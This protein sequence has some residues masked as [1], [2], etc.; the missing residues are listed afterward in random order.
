M[1]LPDKRC[2]I[3]V[4]QPS[5][6]LNDCRMGFNPAIDIFLVE[7]D[8][9]AFTTY[10][11][12]RVPPS[13]GF[14]YIYKTDIITGHCR[15][16]SGKPNQ[17]IYHTHLVDKGNGFNMGQIILGNVHFFTGEIAQP[18]SS[19]AYFSGQSGIFLHTILNTGHIYIF[20]HRLQPFASQD[21]LHF[22]TGRTDFKRNFIHPLRQTP[23]D[24]S[25]PFLR[26]L[27]TDNGH[28]I[29][30]SFALLNFCIQLVCIRGNNQRTMHHGE[31]NGRCTSLHGFGIATTLIFGMPKRMISITSELI[32]PQV[33][34]QLLKAILIK[35]TL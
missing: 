5:C 31:V 18:R 17:C 2:R 4:V 15:L 23:G 20:G 7:L 28:A 1:I 34:V 13:I 9:D 3:V 21:F 24:C 22:C 14:L 27:I 33:F 30:I 32:G 35:G 8:K 11:I 29:I 6:S 25:D 12:S 10:F 19:C 16:N 26:L